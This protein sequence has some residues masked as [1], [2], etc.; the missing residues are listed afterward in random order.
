MRGTLWFFFLLTLMAG[1][2]PSRCEAAA[3]PFMALF[4]GYSKAVSAV[5]LSPD[6]RQAAT[7]GQDNLLRLWDLPTGLLLRTFDADTTR[8]T[9]VSFSPDGR[10]LLTGGA[11]GQ[12]RLFDIATGQ[13]TAIFEAHTGEVLAARFMPSGMRVLSAGAD[14]DVKLW[15]LTSPAPLKTL[16]A[17]EGGALAV[18]VSSNGSRVLSGGRDRLVKLWDLETGLLLKTFKGHSGDVTAVAF[19]PDGAEAL[20]A[21]ADKSITLWDLSSGLPLRTFEGH[22][23]AVTAAAFIGGG[24]QALS[25]SQDKTLKLWETKTGRLIRSLEGH[26]DG[27]TSAAIAVN[28]R[29]ALSGSLDKTLK[30]WDLTEGKVRKTVDLQ[31]AAFSPDGYR[32]FFR[33][34]GLRPKVDT[35]SVGAKL[36]AKGL[37]LGAPV[38]L[39]IFKADLEV[40]LWLKAG[41]RFALFETYPLCAWSGQLGPK[42]REGDGQAPEGFYTIGKGQLNPNSHYHRAFNLG[43]PNALDRS[44]NRTGSNLMVH[45]AC[46]SIGCYAMTDEGIDEIWMLATAALDAG[47]ERIAVHAFPFRMTGDRLEAFS[48][49]PEANFWARLKIAYDYFEEDRVPPRISV[50]N[51]SYQVERGNAGDSIAPALQSCSAQVSPF[52]GTVSINEGTAR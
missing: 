15:E 42:I 16:S 1:L 30:L 26:T 27:V 33:G 44:L 52:R 34:V 23:E 2:A 9:A 45:G 48:W 20:S 47:Q 5:A 29:I 11:N 4:L 39:R 41:N 21:S 18:D 51:K 17:H 13:A 43:Y 46:A 10:Q 40:E 24:G 35:A 7:G 22:T 19:S 50:C 6:E 25:A 14:G 37:R 31:T 36:R 49:H 32:N 3:N 28:G 8:I 38:F 12:L